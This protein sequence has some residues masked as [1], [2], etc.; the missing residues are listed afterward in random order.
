MCRPSPAGGAGQ[1]AVV[2]VGNRVRRLNATKNGTVITT[3]RPAGC[4]D[5]TCWLQAP[6]HRSTRAADRPV[7]QIDLAC[8]PKLGVCWETSAPMGHA[9][10]VAIHSVWRDRH[11][12]VVGGPACADHD[13]ERAGPQHRLIRLLSNSPLASQLAG[14]RH[15]RAIRHLF[16]ATCRPHPSRPPSAATYATKFGDSTLG[17]ANRQAGG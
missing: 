16:W 14:Q 10:S 7:P 4:W 9:A 5:T 8:V 2:R 17:S 12:K 6:A 11:C 3:R 1:T 13:T 15:S